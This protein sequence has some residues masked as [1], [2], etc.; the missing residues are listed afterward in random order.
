MKPELLTDAITQYG[1]NRRRIQRWKV[2]VPSWT[3]VTRRVWVSCNVRHNAIPQSPV[4]WG[5]GW[6]LHT[7]NMS[8]FPR[9]TLVI[10]FLLAY[11]TIMPCPLRIWCE[12]Q[13]CRFNRGSTGDSATFLVTGSGKC[14]WRK[15][16]GRPYTNIH[17]D[18]RAGVVDEWRAPSLAPSYELRVNPNI[19][20]MVG[21]VTFKS[22]LNI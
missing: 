9:S 4:C 19:E 10:H 1:S 12:L 8:H 21:R 7:Y 5:W 13:R 22:A 14:Y 15:Q 3:Q 16:N 2:Q 17:H 11:E 6:P 20:L 18:A